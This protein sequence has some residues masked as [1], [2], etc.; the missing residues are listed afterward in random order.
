MN[1]YNSLYD[2]NNSDIKILC[3]L[4]RRL[5]KNVNNKDDI[6]NVVVKKS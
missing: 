4:I 1:C 6:N 3:V 2:A 5:D